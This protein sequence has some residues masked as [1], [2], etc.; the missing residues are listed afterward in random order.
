MNSPHFNV[1][2]GGIR[3]P[4]DNISAR[5]TTI[6]E[7]IRSRYPYIDRIAIA[8][9]DAATDLLKTFV[10]SNQDHH[11]LER[12]EAHLCDVPSLAHLAKTRQSRIVDD[13]SR[14]F[15]VASKHTQWLMERG[16]RSSLTV[17]IYHGDTLTAFL[18]FDSKYAEA[19]SIESAR[20]LEIFADLIAQLFLV[21][22]TAVHGLSSVVKVATGLARVRDLETGQHL[23]R[24]AHYSRLI[25]RAT[26]DQF[27]LNDEFIEYLFLFA[28]LH[29]IGKVGTPDY[30][31][32]K[33][34]KLDEQEW[35]I[36]QNHVEIGVNIVDKMV[37]DLRLENS[38]AASV[39]RNVVACHHER[40]GGAGYPLGLSMDQIPVEGRIVA[41]ADVY[42]AL[43][44]RRP[45]KD[46]WSEED[47]VA[48]LNKEVALG[49]LDATC[50]EALIAARAERQE[51][52]RTFAD[53]PDIGS[54]E[55][56]QIGGQR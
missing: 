47:S 2:L 44:N 22:L 19:F 10:G 48:E 32:L 29:D 36:M 17:P 52:Q 18:F 39:M 41:I 26:S 49:R 56:G 16:Y 53:I 12:H 20:F 9:Y 27:G 38:L 5:L 50:T 7:V 54:M 23:E 21:Q 46:A 1:L 35:A 43:S 13:I 6:H 42:D 30:V 51:I 3:A 15:P 4:G 25:A 55:S 37:R 11:Q 28:P 33:P 45:Y 24:M 8:L 40:G 34:G 14:T 31:L